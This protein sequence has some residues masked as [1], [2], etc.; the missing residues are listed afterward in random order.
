MEFKGFLSQNNNMLLRLEKFQ[1]EVQLP[2]NWS[3]ALGS[4]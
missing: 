1:I 2:Q 4:L 3:V